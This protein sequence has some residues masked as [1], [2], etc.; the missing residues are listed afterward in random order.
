MQVNVLALR[1]I[2][3]LLNRVTE[4]KNTL[5][6]YITCHVGY[7]MLHLPFIDVALTGCQKKVSFGIIPLEIYIKIKLVHCIKDHIFSIDSVETCLY[8]II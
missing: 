4:S 7:V 6:V 5:I 1:Y 8:K 2:L 3:A